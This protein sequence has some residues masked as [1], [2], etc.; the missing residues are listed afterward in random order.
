MQKDHPNI[1]FYW[2][3]GSK[4][5]LTLCKASPEWCNADCPTITVVDIEPDKSK[6]INGFMV[7]SSLTIESVPEW[8]RNLFIEFVVKSSEAFYRNY[9]HCNSYLG[10]ADIFGTP[11]LLR[12][13]FVEN[14]I[15]DNNLAPAT[16]EIIRQQ[17]KYFQHFRKAP[18]LP[19]A[20]MTF[21]INDNGDQT[22]TTTLVDTEYDLMQALAEAI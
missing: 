15:K 13:G 11:K 20:K 4:H 9:P 1:R 5:R 19:P 14:L 16:V 22:S 17:L 21:V 2:E 7:N 18:E 10:N 8:I 3:D 6:N 12:N